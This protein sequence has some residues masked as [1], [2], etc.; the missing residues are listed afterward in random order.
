VALRAR[1]ASVTRRAYS[2]RESDEYS[3]SSNRKQAQ[4][5]QTNI[6]SG[7]SGEPDY[8]GDDED[9]EDG[10]YAEVDDDGKEEEGDGV[11]FPI[12]AAALLAAW[13]VFVR[14]QKAAREGTADNDAW[15][16]N[17]VWSDMSSMLKSAASQPREE[18][19]ARQTLPAT[20]EDA[21]Y[22]N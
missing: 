13:V 6:N 16:G 1:A 7:G 8:Y 17:S 3:S 20:S 5:K 22:N 9:E 14:K 19:R 11:V 2:R 12:S 18:G 21:V 15:F 10:E 4:C